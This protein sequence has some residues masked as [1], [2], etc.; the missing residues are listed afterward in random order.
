MGRSDCFA[1]SLPNAEKP[2]QPKKLI[3]TT[4]EPGGNRALVASA[5]GLRPRDADTRVGRS[6]TAAVSGNP[7][8]GRLNLARGRRASNGPVGVFD[9]DSSQR[10]S[11]FTAAS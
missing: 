2:A 4:R 10:S 8:W 9:V 7:S 3:K 6:K 11:S 1:L 5:S